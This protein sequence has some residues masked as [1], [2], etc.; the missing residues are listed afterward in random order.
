MYIEKT[1]VVSSDS[2]DKLV[3]EELS[4]MLQILEE[5]YEDRKMNRGLFLAIFDHDQTRDLKKIKKL[6]RAYKRVIAYCSPVD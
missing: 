5:Q 3:V 1:V 4:E 6:I 2:L